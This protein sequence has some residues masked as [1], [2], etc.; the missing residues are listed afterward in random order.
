MVINTNGGSRTTQQMCKVK[1]LNQPVWFHPEYITNVLSYNLLKERYR[2][3]S[4]T[5]VEDVFIVHRPNK[6]DMRFKAF[7]GGLYGLELEE[8]NKQVSLVNLVEDNTPN[9]TK[10]Q[11]EDSKKAMQLIETMVFPSISTSKHAIDNG[12]INNC[13]ITSKN[14]DNYIKIFGTPIPLLKGKGTRKTPKVVSSTTSQTPTEILDV[15]SNITLNIDT[16]FIN[17]I[18]S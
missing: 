8:D 11:V 6:K 16:F 18:I 3:T 9:F 15:N 12:I 5:G 17:K 4:D 1:G 10:R 14:I 7:G 2:I 13:P